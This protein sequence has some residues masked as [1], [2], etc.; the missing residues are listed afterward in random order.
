MLEI[1][2]AVA[3]LGAGLT[4]AIFAVTPSETIKLV[5]APVVLCYPFDGIGRT[6]L[7]DDAQRPKPQY[8]GLLHGTASI[9][10]QEGISGVYQGLV[11]VVSQSTDL[12]F[13]SFKVLI[14]PSVLDDAPGSQLCCPLHNVFDLETV[15]AGQCSS[16]TNLAKY[17][18]IWHWCDRRVGDCL[19]NY[20]IG[21]R[22]QLLPEV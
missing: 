8:R 19:H 18:H 21:V 16:W 9:I 10:R 5:P 7:I 6:K 2:C 3:G 20:A 11:P 12:L 15:C 17:Y 22:F 14:F 13:E 1:N 4:E